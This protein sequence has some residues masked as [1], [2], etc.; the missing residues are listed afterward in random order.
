VAAAAA[1]HLEDPAQDLI[2]RQL[3]AIRLR[4]ADLAWSLATDDFHKKFETSK[5]FLSHLRFQLRPIYNHEDYKFLD[6]PATQDSAQ[7]SMIRKVEM[8]DPDGEPITVIYR[9]ERQGGQW[10]IDSFAVLPSEADPI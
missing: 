7:D 10:L 9:L 1:M 4:D 8:A 5:D 3:H 6:Q 2:S